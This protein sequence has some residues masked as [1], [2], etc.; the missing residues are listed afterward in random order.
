MED[1]GLIVLVVLGG[2]TLVLNLL[3]TYITAN[4]YFEV[5]N[6][7]RNQIL[8]IWLVPVLGACLAIFINRE[9]FFISKHKDKVG[10]QPEITDRQA[11]SFGNA[12]NRNK[13]R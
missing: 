5:M 4:T 8:F 12:A 13:F 3:A 9:D 10:N 2:L 11:V 1:P 7:K 6:R